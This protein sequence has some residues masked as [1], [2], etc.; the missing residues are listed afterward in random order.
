MIELKSP[1]QIA[2][3][4]EAGRVV[5]Q[6]LAAARTAAEPGVRL[7]EL[8]RIAEET[9]R[10]AGAVPSFLGYQP[11]FSRSP[12]PATLC[13][14]V[15]EAIV[16][17]IPD[18]Y[19]IQEGDLVS[20]DCG[21]VLNGYHGDSAVTVGVGSI[22]E[23]ARRLLEM[24]E[25]AL[26]AGIAQARP[27][28]RI[29]DISRAVGEVGHEGGYGIV[30]DFGGHGIGRALHESPQILNDVFPGSEGQRKKLKAGLVIAIEPMFNEGSEAYELL[31]DDWTLVTADGRRSAHFEHTVAITADGP[32]ILTLE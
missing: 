9:I 10:K 11:G 13:L 18:E 25:R 5:A 23:P 4:R 12:F 29:V 20:I 21:A 3:M 31:D 17:G 2:T 28:N 32:Q 16:H 26:H 6:A 30:P 19:E 7:R 15:N 22:D 14:S 27:G 8:D 1:D 24:T